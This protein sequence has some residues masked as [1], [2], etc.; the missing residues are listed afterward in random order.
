MLGRITVLAKIG[1]RTSHTITSYG[2]EHGS[3]TLKGVVVDGYTT[4][5][6]FRMR[7]TLEVPK[8]LNE[9]GLL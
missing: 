1:G 5:K 4:S 8:N 3:R 7:F 9:A 6:V 2:K